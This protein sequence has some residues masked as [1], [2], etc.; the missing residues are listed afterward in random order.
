MCYFLPQFKAVSSS[1]FTE[2]FIYMGLYLTEAAEL[3][4]DGRQRVVHHTL[5]LAADALGQLP[6]TEVTRLDVPLNQRHGE[7]SLRHK[8]QRKC[9]RKTA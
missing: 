5:Q 9:K 8:L 2:M 7:A 4:D 3:A 1:L 6:S